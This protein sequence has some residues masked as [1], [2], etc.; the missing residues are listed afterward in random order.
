MD[1]E[2]GRGSGEPASYPADV[3]L[4][5]V[6][7]GFERAGFDGHFDIDDDSGTCL[8]ASCGQ[9]AA[10]EEIEALEARR[11][12]GASDPAEMAIVLGLGCPHC[13]RRGTVVCRYGPEASAGEAALVRASRGATGR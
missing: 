2:V 11:L 5:E 9:A 7:S 12:E 3:S 1:P 4:A 10:P 8:C 6:L 13:G